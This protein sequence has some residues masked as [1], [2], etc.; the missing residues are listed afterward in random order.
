MSTE[1]SRATNSAFLGQIWPK[2]KL[3]RDI[4]ASLGQNKKIVQLGNPTLPTI[5]VPT[6]FF[7]SSFAEHSHAL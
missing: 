7:F 3:I 4:I 1:Y 5:L 6:L 2:S